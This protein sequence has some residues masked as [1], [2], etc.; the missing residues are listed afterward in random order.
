MI[1][2]D[3]Q[4]VGTRFPEQPDK[5]TMILHDTQAVGTRFP[6]QPDKQPAMFSTQSDARL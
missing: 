6:E 3:T 1:L 5:H 4:A 2:H